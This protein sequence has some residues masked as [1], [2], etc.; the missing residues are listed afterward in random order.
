MSKRAD[1][2]AH[3]SPQRTAPA[4]QCGQA[5]TLRLNLCKV[6]HPRRGLISGGNFVFNFGV[7]VSV[8]DGERLLVMKIVNIFVFN[9][10]FIITPV[11]IVAGRIGLVILKR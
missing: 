8:G 5:S 10:L 3:A 7:I 6:G 4:I 2:K 11:F 9:P 1:C